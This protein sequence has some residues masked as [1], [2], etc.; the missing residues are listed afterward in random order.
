[1]TTDQFGSF[2]PQAVIEPTEA[3][4]LIVEDNAD[5]LFIVT[6]LL[7][8]EV[9]VRHCNARASGR[10]LYKLLESHPE[11]TIHLILLDIQI[12]GEDGYAVLQHLRTLPALAET[13]VVAVTANVMPQDEARLRAVGFDGFIG[14]PISRRRFPD[15]IRRV[16]AGEAVW[17]AR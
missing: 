1:M 15:Q 10:Q 13:R 17:E 7:K 6:D 14:K 16:L 2:R 5:N 9:R 11:R 4:V 3:I 12:P 8:E